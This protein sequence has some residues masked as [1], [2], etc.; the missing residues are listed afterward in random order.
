MGAGQGNERA[1][2]SSGSGTSQPPL[3]VPMIVRG[4]PLRQLPVLV[5]DDYDVVQIKEANARF[6][7]KIIHP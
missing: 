4:H 3:F 7:I 6:T 1:E 5:T 2:T